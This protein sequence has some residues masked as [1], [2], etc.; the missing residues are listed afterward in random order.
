M[1]LLTPDSPP[2]PPPTT[3]APPL[4]CAHAQ[5][6]LQA[7]DNIA[8]VQV[9]RTGPDGQVR[10]RLKPATRPLRVH[11]HPPPLPVPPPPF[12]HDCVSDPPAAA[13]AAAA[14]ASLA[15]LSA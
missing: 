6:A 1:A 13:A 10:A 4:P 3:H 2:P 5:A 9:R 8:V 11:S 7:L 15:L 12:A 14:A